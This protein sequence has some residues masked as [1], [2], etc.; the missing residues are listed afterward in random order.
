MKAIQDNQVRYGYA[1][2]RYVRPRR[3]LKPAMAVLTLLL[4]AAVGGLFCGLI[5]GAAR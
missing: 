5:A 3:W 2:T 1:G 4:V